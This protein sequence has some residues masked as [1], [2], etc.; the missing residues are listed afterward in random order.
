L[1]IVHWKLYQ[2][3]RAAYFEQ[4]YPFRKPLA[5]IL[6]GISSVNFFAFTDEVKTEN[7]LT[8]CLLK[9]IQDEITT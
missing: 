5:Y 4:L 1:Y 9:R 7:T 3:H 8:S 2:Y 6:N